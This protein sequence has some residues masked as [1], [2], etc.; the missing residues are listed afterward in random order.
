MEKKLDEKERDIKT[1][2]THII[3]MEEEGRTLNE[4]FRN[5]KVERDTFAEEIE[6]LRI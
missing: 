4:D 2:K 6:R 3:K 5:L 1:S